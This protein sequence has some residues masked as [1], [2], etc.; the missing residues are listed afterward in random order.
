[1]QDTRLQRVGWIHTGYGTVAPVCTRILC[2]R[3]ACRARWESD[4][5]NSQCTA[6][7]TVRPGIGQTRLPEGVR[8]RRVAVTWQDGRQADFAQVSY[9]KQ[10]H[11]HDTSLARM[12]VLCRSYENSRWPQTV[13]ASLRCVSTL[14]NL[15]PNP[16]TRFSVFVRSNSV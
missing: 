1:M 10:R 5:R 13:A 12:I 15:V 8:S 11:E 2:R 14:I 6:T 16:N 7:L 4:P 3:N 9:F